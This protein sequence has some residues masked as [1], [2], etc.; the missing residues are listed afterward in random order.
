MEP[1]TIRETNGINIGGDGSKMPQTPAQDIGNFKTTDFRIT[2]EVLEKFGYT[3]GCSG[4]EAK[5]LGTEHRNFM[6]ACRMRFEETM[7]SDEKMRQTIEKRD[8]RIKRKEKHHGAEQSQQNHEV[9]SSGANSDFK[10]EPG[11][12]NRH[13]DANEDEMEWSVRM[14]FCRLY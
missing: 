6:A 14:T 9:P 11:Y 2:F 13:M 4:S 8:S 3:K 7:S 1:N 10:T 5:L 12:E